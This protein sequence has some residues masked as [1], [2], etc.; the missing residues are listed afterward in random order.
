MEHP[1]DH[2]LKSDDS[3]SKIDSGIQ[4]PIDNSL[5]SPDSIDATYDKLELAMARIRQPGHA[6]SP[7]G[8]LLGATSTEFDDPAVAPFAQSLRL[9]ALTGF[10]DAQALLP[11]TSLLINQPGVSLSDVNHDDTPARL[12]IANRFEL[13]G[14][15]GCGSFGVVY[16]AFDLLA[17]REV[18]LKCPRPELLAISAV[19]DRFF[20]EGAAISEIFHPG[21]VPLLD[22]GV[23]RGLPYLVSRL[24][25]GPSLQQWLEQHEGPIRPEIAA[26]WVRQLAEAVD[27]LHSHGILHCDLKPSNILLEHPYADN[28]AELPPELLSICVTDFGSAARLT[29]IH[30]RNSGH[31]EGALCYMAPEQISGHDRPDARTDVYSICAVLFELLTRQPVF[32]ADNS[33]ELERQILH[34]IPAVSMQPPAEIPYALQMIM[35]KGLA[36]N[37]HD[38]YAGAAALAA[39]LDAWLNHRTPVVL[40]NSIEY[41][42]E[43]WLWRNRAAAAI[44]AM[45][46]L[47]TL[48]YGSFQLQQIQSARRVEIERMRNAWQQLYVNSIVA[49]SKY[50]YLNNQ[51]QLNSILNSIQLPPQETSLKADPREFAWRHLN[52]MSRPISTVVGGLPVDV[53]HY[54]MHASV[55]TRSLWAGGADGFVREIDTTK[56]RVIREIKL[57]EKPIESIDISPDGNLLA[58]GNDAGEVKIFKLPELTLISRNKLHSGEVADLKFSRDSQKIITSGRNGQIYIWR[59]NENVVRSLLKQSKSGESKFA[60]LFGI[61]LLADPNLAAVGTDRGEI[62]IVD[63]QKVD[64]AYSLRGHHDAVLSLVLS[65]DAKWMVSA[66]LDNSLCIWDL[67][68]QL[69]VNRINIQETEYYNGI[70]RGSGRK[71]PWISQVVHI[72]K[73]SCVAFDSGNGV[74]SIYHIPSGIK[75]GE[76]RGNDKPAWSLAYLPWSKQLVSFSRDLQMRVWNEPFISNTTGHIFH[77]DLA[78]ARLQNEMPFLWLDPAVTLPGSAN[79][80]EIRPFVSPIDYYI[81][82]SAWSNSNQD[83][84]VLVMKPTPRLKDPAVH[85]VHLLKS[86]SNEAISQSYFQNG[87]KSIFKYSAEARLQDAKLAASPEK[88]LATLITTDRKLH[89]LDYSNPDNPEDFFIEENVNHSIFI[90]DTDQIL[91]LTDGLKPPRFYDYIKKEWLGSWPDDDG[92][93][94]ILA[95]LSPDKSSLAVH[96][97][98]GRLQFWNFSGRTLQNQTIIPEVGQRRFREIRWMPDSSEVVVAMG[99]KDLFLIDRKTGTVMLNWDMG[100][101]RILKT[102]VAGNGESIW[103]FDTKNPAINLPAYS[104]RITRIAAPKTEINVTREN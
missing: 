24:V 78:P 9:L 36:K 22:I 66:S 103:V 55:A 53:P 91:V 98:P 84:L 63:I 56:N 80:Q 21:V 7:V 34:S 30:P 2:G 13:R 42:L 62:L 65:T 83:Y 38:R 69:L 82:D 90:P 39:D 54:V 95:E 58:I 101:S 5:L 61:T 16:R 25:N 75:M 20:V 48:L 70:Q 64:V 3:F 100:N 88:P 93:G 26:R 29:D 18:A 68:K 97:A 46:A 23:H 92:H 11:D 52:E 72:D 87:K 79:N 35:L 89:F 104:R 27:H 4:S 74:I 59:I 102:M 41:R 6:D 44:M 37:P 33:H 81:T 51:S 12:C 8:A 94:W 49:A 19:R 10:A 28:P 57:Q 99:T 31:V 73:L 43:T 45:V 15:I 76:L 60:E 77:F 1:P 85:Q 14:R 50:Y 47:V 96:R 86:K 32:A 40:M 67:E 17:Q 71:I